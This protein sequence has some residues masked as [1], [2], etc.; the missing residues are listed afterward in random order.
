MSW[1]QRPLAGALSILVL[2]GC[3]PAYE[4]NARRQLRSAE[5]RLAPESTEPADA[6]QP[7]LDGSLGGYV[8]FAMRNSP[9]LRAAFEDWRAATFRI[10]RTRRLPQPS[11]SY[12]LFLRSVETRVGPQRHRFGLRQTLPWPTGLRAAADATADLARAAERDFEAEALRLERRV[13][14]AYWQLWLTQRRREIERSQRELLAEFSAAA[15]VRV[16]IGKASLAD[17][18]QIDLGVSRIDDMLAGRDAEETRARVELIA[19]IGA[20]ANIDTPISAGSVVTSVPAEED[21]RLRAAVTAH[22]RIDAFRWRAS[23]SDDRVRQARAQGM[24]SLTLGLDYIETGS[25][26][27][28]GVEDSGKDPIVASVSIALPLWRGSYD[29]DAQRARAE[30]SAMRFKER[31]AHDQAHAELEKHLASVR[32]TGRRILL[33]EQTLTVQAET[34]YR[35]VVGNYQTANASL[36]SVL[37]AQREVLDIHLQLA[38]ARAEHARAWS[39]LRE[40]VGRDVQS[41]E[42][43]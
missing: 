42:I 4:R 35:A 1:Q 32:D 14:E 15:R 20:P 7:T 23:S 11:I 34:V 9:A 19:A 21:A 3:A 18:A 43:P 40:V 27:A 13:A 41:K 17:L 8:A 37:L 33:Y 28:P 29:K 36:A 24:P 16:E 31:A 6:D 2:A 5:A 26:S 10:A 25:A 30:A 22:P 38:T 12:G 39:R